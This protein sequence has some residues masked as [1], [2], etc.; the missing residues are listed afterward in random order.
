MSHSDFQLGDFLDTGH[1]KSQS[2]GGAPQ[3]PGWDE[4]DRLLGMAEQQSADVPAARL[5]FPVNAMPFQLSNF[6]LD[7]GIDTRE[8][9][10]APPERPGSRPSQSLEGSWEKKEKERNTLR[11]PKPVHPGLPH[12]PY[13][14][15]PLANGGGVTISGSSSQPVPSPPATPYI[16]STN[17]TPAVRKR[18][19]TLPVW[20][21]EL[22]NST[23]GTP[24]VRTGR[25]NPPVWKPTTTL[26]LSPHEL[27]NSTNGAVSTGSSTSPVWKPTT[28]LP[29][30]PPE[31]GHSITPPPRP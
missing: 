27:D 2:S 11:K 23:N 28:P 14:M 20:K 25:G 31:P 7:Q 15:P 3:D 10:L 17:G 26:P 9:Q 8:R 4:E 21:P 1:S 24:A 19:D 12:A 29:L 6:T 18:S 16:V 13:S 5:M 30:P 22:D